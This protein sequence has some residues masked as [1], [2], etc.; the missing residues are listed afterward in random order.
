MKADYT[1]V[2]LYQCF[3]CPSTILCPIHVWS[4]CLFNIWIS[5]FSTWHSLSS[6]FILIKYSK[7]FVLPQFIIFLPFSSL[8]QVTDAKYKRLEIMEYFRTSNVRWAKMSEIIVNWT[9]LKFHQE[10]YLFLVKSV[11]FFHELFIF[12]TWLW[13]FYFEGL[14]EFWY[15]CNLT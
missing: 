6:A 11:H 12:Q 9:F 13:H 5:H 10:S 8:A 7:Y 1:W 15:I 14:I 4:F 3:P 2:Y